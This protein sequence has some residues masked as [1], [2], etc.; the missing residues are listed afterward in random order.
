[1]LDKLK[2]GN[3]R[4]PALSP[5]V[6]ALAREAWVQASLTYGAPQVRSGHIL[7]ALLLDD[8]LAPIA[9]EGS[10]QFAKIPPETLQERMVF[11]MVN[12]AAR[13]LDEQVVREARDLD[14]AMVMGTGFPPFRGGL[15]RHADTLGIPV[16]V[17]R[18]S[19]LADAH[20]D[21]FRPT[22]SLDQMVR[23]QARFHR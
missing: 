11:I 7:A 16:V 19:R 4:A 13:C 2:T 9:R 14:L 18:L 15:L 3:S 8:S 12:E 5:H 6:V 22:A 21:R 23:A 20:G 17:D 1:M 10:A